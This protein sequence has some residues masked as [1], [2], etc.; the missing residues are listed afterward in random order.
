VSAAQ[1]Q[2]RRAP[3]LPSPPGTLQ[4]IQDIQNQIDAILQARA[5]AEA[6]AEVMGEERARGQS[7]VAPIQGAVQQGQQAVTAAQA[8]QQT[9]A[10]RTAAN[11]EQQGR[12]QQAQGLI[13]GYASRASGLGVIKVPL[14]AFQGFTW[15]AGKLPGGAGAAMRRMNDDANKMNAAFGQMDL[16]MSQQEQTQPQQAER[17]RNDSTRLGAAGTQA[18]TAHDQLGTSVQGGQSLQQ[19]NQGSL[20]QASAAQQQAQGE[21]AALDN[22]AQTQQAKK[23]SLVEQM[24]GWATAHRQARLGGRSPGR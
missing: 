21:G 23:K 12:Q 5:R 13:A 9:V 2:Q 18:N 4:Q 10:A 14:K 16:A 11:Q 15:I 22:A 7:N 1:Q 24:F 17:L 20:E 19:A 8:Q 3:N 6:T